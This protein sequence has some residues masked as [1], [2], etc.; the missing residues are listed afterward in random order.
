[1][2]RPF[3][4]NRFSETGTKTSIGGAVV[5]ERCS[6]YS[7]D[8]I[9]KSLIYQVYCH[10][11]TSTESVLVIPPLNG[12]IEEQ[13]NEMNELG[14]PAVHLNPNS[15]ECLFDGSFSHMKLIFE[16]YC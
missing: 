13:V 7:S 5:W 14:I 4:E 9:G 10:A 1:M 2:S 6:G 8:G 12:I 15:Q 3:S 11:R 16:L